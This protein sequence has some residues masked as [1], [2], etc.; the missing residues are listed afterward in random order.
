[1]I[2][3]YRDLTPE[4]RAEQD[5]TFDV[6]PLPRVASGA[7]IAHDVRPVHLLGVRAP[8][9]GGRPPDRGDLRR[10]RRDPGRDRLRD[11][12]QPRR[13]S[14]A[15]TSSRR[16]SVR[17]TPTSSP[18]R[19]ATPGCCRARRVAGRAA[20]RRP[21]T[22]T[23]LFYEPV[24]LPLQERLEAIDAASVPLF[25]PPETPQLAV[26]PTPSASPSD[27]LSGRGADSGSVGLRR[28]RVQ[29]RLGDHRRGDLDLPA[30]GRPDGRA[31]RPTAVSTSAGRSPGGFHSTRR[32]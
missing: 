20:A 24:I 30:R 4:L 25:D 19:C 8:R 9:G 16:V 3:G 18:A 5:L 10:G 32:R 22:L 23:Q 26:G 1:M 27:S 21:A 11:A 29:D 28:L 13:R 15:T 7:T 14:T 31:P 6:M 17:C 2:L 12:V